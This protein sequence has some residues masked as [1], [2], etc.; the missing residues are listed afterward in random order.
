MNAVELWEALHRQRVTLTASDDRLCINAPKGALT[1]ALRQQIRQH[2][3]ALLA[4]LS[5]RPPRHA[6]GFPVTLTDTPCVLCGSVEWQQHVTYRY[7]L[8]CGQ[9]AGPGA[10]VDN[11]TEAF[12]G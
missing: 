2:K 8:S 9:E 12:H 5:P 4:I 10:I 11:R 1:D 3:P 7:C 6:G